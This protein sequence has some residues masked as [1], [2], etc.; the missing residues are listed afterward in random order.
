[1]YGEYS[2]GCLS[3][4]KTTRVKTTK[5]NENETQGKTG[6]ERLQGKILRERQ[7]RKRQKKE[8][9][10]L[11]TKPAYCLSASSWRVILLAA[12][13]PSSIIFLIAAAAS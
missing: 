5:R 10:D 11:V 9:G 2:Q 6:Q 8:E 12:V 1:M 4:G 7:H 3:K 13:F